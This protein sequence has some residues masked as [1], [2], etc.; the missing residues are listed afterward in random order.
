MAYFVGLGIFLAGIGV[1]YL[2]AWRK[3]SD[4]AAQSWSA[5]FKDGRLIGTKPH[6]EHLVLATLLDNLKKESPND[7]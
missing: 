5:G 4:V 6:G 7:H 1:G 2:L 3:L